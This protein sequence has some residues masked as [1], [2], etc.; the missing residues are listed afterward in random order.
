MKTKTFIENINMVTNNFLDNQA[1]L[2]QSGINERT[3]SA[4]FAHELINSGLFNEYDIDC[5][6]NRLDTEIKRLPPPEDCESNDTEGK[7]IYPDI[8][9][10]KRGKSSDNLAVIEIKK[11]NNSDTARDIEKLKALTQQNGGYAY[12]YGVH[13]TFDIFKKGKTTAACYQEGEQTHKDIL[14]K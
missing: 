9:I 1:D 12:T 13:L 10:H 3:L 6:Y 2:L 5:E 4:Q 7:T 8:L 11:S 14:E